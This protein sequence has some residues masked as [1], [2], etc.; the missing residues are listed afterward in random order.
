M[1]PEIGQSVDSDLMATMIDSV[2]DTRTKL[3]Q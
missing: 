3:G 1:G 2:L